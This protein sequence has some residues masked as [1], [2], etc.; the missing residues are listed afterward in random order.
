MGRNQ[1]SSENMR[2]PTSCMPRSAVGVSSCKVCCLARADAAPPK[3]T[4]NGL[5]LPRHVAARD[6]TQ[7]R[8]LREK[9]LKR[10]EKRHRAVR[11]GGWAQLG[12]DQHLPQATP[13]VAFGTPPPLPA[14]AKPP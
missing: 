9:G 6:S 12:L 2:A 7:H 13:P 14:S 1:E 8:Y 5:R 3:W 10:A 11:D 4:P